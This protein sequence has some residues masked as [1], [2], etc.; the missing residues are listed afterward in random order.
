M[1]L[2]RV[3]GKIKLRHPVQ[4]SL[5]SRISIPLLLNGGTA[6]KEDG[7]SIKGRNFAVPGHFPLVVMLEK[8]ERIMNLPD[9]EICRTQQIRESSYYWCMVSH[10]YQCS[11]S[12][13]IGDS[14]FCNHPERCA[15]TRKVE[16]DVN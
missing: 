7:R 10:P 5:P 13:R 16:E 4:S 1:S 11:Y 8:C 12:S 6:S 14:C 3:P 9:P 2:T 15:F